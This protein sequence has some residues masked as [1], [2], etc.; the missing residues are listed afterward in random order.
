IAPQWTI[1][2]A[3]DTA[4][5]GVLGD[6]VPEYS[7][8]IWHGINTPLL[9]SL[10]GV[11]C[12]VLLYAGLRRLLELHAGVRQSQGRKLFHLNIEALLRFGRRF[13]HTVANGSMQRSLLWLL[14]VA[15]AAGAAPF[16]AAWGEP[17][18]PVVFAGQP[19]V[20]LAWV[21][22]WMLVCCALA[23]LALYRHR[24]VAVLVMGGCGLAVSMTFVALSAPDLALT[25]LLVELV[26]VALMRSEER[27]VGEGGTC[28]G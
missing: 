23:T 27:R 9:M 26:T 16:V 1:G 10:G 28:G 2:P 21:L 22:W 6:N 13:T 18:Q 7:L 20:R 5:R 11:V 8:A 24:L 4:A 3:L 15:V 19:M 17:T 25:Q 12:G 14:M